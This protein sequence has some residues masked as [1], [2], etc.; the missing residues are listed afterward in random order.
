VCLSIT[1]DFCFG[2]SKD[3][4]FHILA[5]HLKIFSKNRYSTYLKEEMMA[6]KSQTRKQAARKAAAQRS[7]EEKSA[8]SRKG[9]ETQR[10]HELER[11]GQL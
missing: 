3:P 6:G 10:K 4:L 2:Q 11:K 8:A 7:H 9:V 1:E 5:F